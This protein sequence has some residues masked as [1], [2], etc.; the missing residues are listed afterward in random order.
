M[1]KLSFVILVMVTLFLTTCSKSGSGVSTPEVSI[2]GTWKPIKEVDV[3]SDKSKT[4]S[5]YD[6]CQLQSRYIFTKEGTINITEYHNTQ[7]GCVI[8]N[9]SN[10]TFK[11]NNNTLV[12]S[13]DNEVNVNDFLELNGDVLKVGRYENETNNTC[14]INLL[15]THYYT[16]L[17]RVN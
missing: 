4:E 13:I 16:E 12:T 1:K 5:V 6:A 7:S 9:Q 15:V 3:C 14:S 10:G 8:T 2:I 17:V 11:I